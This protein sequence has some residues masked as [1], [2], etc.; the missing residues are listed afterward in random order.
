M[1]ESTNREVNRQ[2]AMIA[3]GLVTAF[4]V[5]SNPDD[6]EA[7]MEWFAE[8]RDGQGLFID[9]EPWDYSLMVTASIDTIVAFRSWRSTIPPFSFA[10]WKALENKRYDDAEAAH[11]RM[12]EKGADRDT[13][14]A[15]EYLSNPFDEEK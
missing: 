12:M 3:N 1:S 4:V 13:D 5:S 8:H 15:L 9:R 11:E 6:R 7:V 14:D 2:V 10:E